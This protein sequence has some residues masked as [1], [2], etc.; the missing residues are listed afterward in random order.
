MREAKHFS[1]FR[2]HV[3]PYLERRVVRKDLR[4]WCAGCSSGEESYT[5][6]MI[7]EDYFQT[8]P[9]WDKTLLATDISS[10]VLEQAVRGEYTGKDV[11]VLPQQWRNRYFSKIGKEKYTVQEQIKSQVVYRK[12]NLIDP[13]FPFKQKFHV[14][15]CRNVMIYFDN[16]TR[17]RLIQKFWDH[18]EKG[19]YLFVGHS[20]SVHREKSPYV[21]MMPGVYRKE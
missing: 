6:A 9:G 8:K 20:E 2:E 21:Y 3:L 5:L 1:Y 11:S 14:I 18:T 16:A 12:F 13:V 17:E 4:I 19:G 7:L 15:F 10:K